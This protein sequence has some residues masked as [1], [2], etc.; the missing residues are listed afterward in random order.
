MLL[1]TIEDAMNVDLE[2]GCCRECGGQL[3]IIGCDDATLTVEC[4][5]GE[6]YSVESDAFNDGCMKYRNLS[7]L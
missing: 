4:E 2:D 7:A 3:K 1:L 6:N 5:C